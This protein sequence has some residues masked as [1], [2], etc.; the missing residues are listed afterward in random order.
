MK[1]LNKIKLILMVLTIGLFS[2][3]CSSD[4]DGGG[5]GP[6]GEGTITFKVDG[7]SVTTLEM[8]TFATYTNKVL[9]VEGNTGGTNAKGIVLQVFGIDGPGT[10]PLGGNNDFFHV[11]AYLEF[12]IDLNNPLGMTEESWQAPYDNTLAGEIKVSELTDTKVVGTFYFK[13]QNVD[14]DESFKQITDGSFNVSL[15]EF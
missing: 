2:L 5:S 1:S 8:V 11:G 13:G 9:M 12:D 4:D 3:S 15:M 14:G 6:A 7:T 10:Y